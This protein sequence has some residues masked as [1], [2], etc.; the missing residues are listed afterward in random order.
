MTVL[1]DSWCWIEYFN[2]T[3]AGSKVAEYI[4]SDMHLFISVINL[5][6]IYRYV[7]IKKTEKE[8]NT[9][10]HVMLS[11]CFIL[12]IEAETALNAAV[13][14]AKKKI[15]LGDSLIYASAKSHNLKVITGDPHFSGEKDV[16]YLGK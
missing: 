15:G 13:I 2:G 16:I 7:L 12:P 4:D 3:K 1:V 6:E 10:V 8:A 11:R 14:N 9:L 5:A